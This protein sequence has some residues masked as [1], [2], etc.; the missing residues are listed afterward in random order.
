MKKRSTRVE[1]QRVDM[2]TGELRRVASVLT[3]NIQIASASLAN[4]SEKQCPAE[5]L[6]VIIDNCAS[7]LF[8]CVVGQIRYEEHK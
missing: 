6:K 5:L 7:G 3:S 4:L 2:E 8:S 1:V